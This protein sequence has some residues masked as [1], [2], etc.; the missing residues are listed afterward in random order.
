[1]TN[2]DFGAFYAAVHGDGEHVRTP[3]PWQERLLEEVL[4]AGWGRAIGVPTGCGKTSVLDVAVFALAAQSHLPF[5]QRPP[6]RTFFVID[7]R[8]VVDDVT[9]HARK[10]ARAIHQATGGIL[11]EVADRLRGFG[12]AVPLQVATLRGGMYRDDAW[13]DAPC[14]PL[15]CVSTVDQVG[16]R[17]LFRGY[18][19]SDSRRPEHAG[20]VGNDALVILDEAHLSKPFADTLRQVQRFQGVADEA[21]VPGIQVVEMSATGNGGVDSVGLT[22]ADFQCETLRP[23]LEASKPARLR[24]A[25][26]LVDA[27]TEEALRLAAAGAG[28]TGV[29][30]NTVA[31]ARGVFEKLRKT[32]A[33]AVLLTGRIRPYDRDRLLEKSLPR[34]KAGRTRNAGERLFVVAT[35]TVEVGA[36]LDFDGLVTEAAPLD[37]LRQRFGRLNRLG[38]FADCRAAIVN[39]RRD[40]RDWVYGE[41]VAAAWKWLQAHAEGGVVD[42]GIR[43]MESL[44]AE[45]GT[46][47]L[48]STK[49][50]GPLLFPAHLD[51][52]A[53]TNPAPAADPDIVP[54][55][56]GQN[57]QSPDVQIVWRADLGDA[58]WIDTLRAAPPMSTEALPVPIGAAK[59]WLAGGEA[60]A[61]DVEGVAEA[62]E[63]GGERRRRYEIWCG[64][65]RVATH[66]EPWPGDVVVVDSREGGADE[67][68]WNPESTAPVPDVGDASHNQRVTAAGG[69]LRL[70]VHAALQ[71]SGDNE[72]RAELRELLRA[73]ASEEDVLDAIRDLVEGQYPGLEAVWRSKPEAYAGGEGL[74]FESKWQPPDKGECGELAEETN[75]DDTASFTSEITLAA[76]TE[77]VV[78][79]AAQ[80]AAPLARRVALSVEKAAEYHD[81]GKWDERFQALIAPRRRPGLAPLAKGEQAYSVAELRRRQEASGYPRGARH[82]F[83]SAALAELAG[84]WPEDFDRELAL[85]LTG[86]HHGRGRSL[87]PVWQAAYAVTAQV[88]GVAVTVDNAAGALARLDSSWTGRYWR[89]TQRYGWW[90]LAYLETILRRADCVRSREER[91]AQ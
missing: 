74:V 83:V 22:E 77:G 30:L 64:P 32:G 41:P 11:L 6:L 8:L 50:D 58:G 43:A 65:E 17:L 31:A 81:L 63:A 73:Y 90:G 36:D 29:V 47:E 40:S 38:E 44:S 23:R 54:F 51:A 13:A 89:L 52:W 1:V 56:H 53:Q 39:A 24:E 12:G 60:D 70:R 62:D 18:G 87:P 5:D 69:R 28:V 4:G 84:E 2:A 15:I 78:K 66:L 19:V 57:A 86:A 61:A 48:N 82:E 46:K 80:Y 59:R 42:F 71:F 16:S 7:R 79:K 20:L 37:A 35:Q 25:A 55:L 91:D 9:R 49:V 34:M 85:H 10:L 3:F 26:N 75:E 68:G 72:K 27:A 14:Q 45:F 67:F 21:A 88:N 76:H 33:D